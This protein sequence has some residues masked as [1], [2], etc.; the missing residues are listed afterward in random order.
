MNFLMKAMLKKQLK[1]LPADQQEKVMAAFEKD[2]K[3]FEDIAKEIKAKMKE[4]ADQQSATMLV[5][6]KNQKKLQD[7]MK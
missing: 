6:M 3:F 7:L 4:G 5:M 2:P 1:Q